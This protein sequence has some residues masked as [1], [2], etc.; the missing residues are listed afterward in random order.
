MMLLTILKYD[1]VLGLNIIDS[2]V[3]ILYF[4]WLSDHGRT[5]HTNVRQ[6]YAHPYKEPRRQHNNIRLTGADAYQGHWQYEP[7]EVLDE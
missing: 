7:G 1:R 2:D 6:R 5:P 3:L 4:W